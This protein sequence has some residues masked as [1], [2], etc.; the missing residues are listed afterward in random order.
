ML[1]DDAGVGGVA[2]HLVDSGFFGCAQ[3]FRGVRRHLQQT[4]DP[5][6]L[7]CACKEWSRWVQRVAHRQF[8]SSSYLSAKRQSFDPEANRFDPVTRQFRVGT[9]NGLVGVNRAQ[10]DLQ[11]ERDAQQNHSPKYNCAPYPNG[12]VGGIKL[13]KDHQSA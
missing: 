8:G 5:R 3:F 11:N 6:V 1:P 13:K 2:N 10:R 9:P 12:H 7:P 4:F